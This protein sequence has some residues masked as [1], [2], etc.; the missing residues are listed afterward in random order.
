MRKRYDKSVQLC[1][2]SE[3]DCPALDARLH[4]HVFA[5]VELVCRARDASSLAHS[6]EVYR[7]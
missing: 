7:S 3:N 6:L 1:G 2:Y 4:D 5:L